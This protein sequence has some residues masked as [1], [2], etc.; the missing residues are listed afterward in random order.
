MFK[1][2]TILDND[3]RDVLATLLVDVNVDLEQVLA[4]IEQVKEDKAG[5][6]V[7][8]DII[9]GISCDYVEIETNCIYV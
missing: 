4:E 6:W 1:A 3:D 2:I 8:T 7:L 5:E 9:E